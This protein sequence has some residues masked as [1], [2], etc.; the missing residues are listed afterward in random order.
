VDLTTRLSEEAYLKALKRDLIKVGLNSS[1]IGTLSERTT[2]FTM[3]PHLPRMDG[4]GQEPSVKSAPPLAGHGAE[5]VRQAIAEA[6]ADLPE[7]LRRS[8]AWDQGAEMA[9]HAQLGARHRAAD[10]L[11]RPAQPLAAGQQRVHQ[12]AAA[13]V[14]PQGHRPVQHSADLA[15]VARALDTRPRK[16]LG[17]KTPAEALNEHLRSLPPAGVAWTP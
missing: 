15:A 11:L 3:L 5:A 10:L 16:S 12:R 1:A 2:R 7:Q 17:W 6:I 14:L 13:P 8:L 4:R 9:Q